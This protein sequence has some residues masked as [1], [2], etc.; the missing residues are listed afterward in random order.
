MGRS[1]LCETNFRVYWSLDGAA[2]GGPSYARPAVPEHVE[3][4]DLSRLRGCK[5]KKGQKKFIGNVKEGVLVTLCRLLTG[6]E[7]QLL[8]PDIDIDI[9]EPT[10]SELGLILC[11]SSELPVKVETGL[12]LVDSIAAA[13]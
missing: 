3:I 1:V 2:S 12:V 9:R 6:L 11:W 7:L 13:S 5:C 8:W 10:L 4:F